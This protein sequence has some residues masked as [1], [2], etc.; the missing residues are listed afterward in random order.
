MRVACI[1]GQAKALNF[2]KVLSRFIQKYLQSSYFFGRRVECAV[3]TSI[4][5]QT[6]PQTMR[7]LYILC[8]AGGL[9]S[10]KRARITGYAA[11][12]RIFSSNKSVPVTANR[13]KGFYTSRLPKM[14]RSRNQWEPLTRWPSANTASRRGG[15]P[16]LS[17][18]PPP[19]SLFCNLCIKELYLRPYS[20][21]F[22]LC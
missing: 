17:P 5:W 7:E 20:N 4:F 9:V 19:S 1:P 2:F 12:W 22:L 8:L 16:L 14:I 15:T 6:G 21:K 11:L 13:K 3:Q 18:P 10:P